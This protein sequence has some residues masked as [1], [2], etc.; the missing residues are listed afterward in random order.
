MCT[1]LAI[2]LCLNFFAHKFEWKNWTVTLTIRAKM[3]VGE[4]QQHTF[5][6]FTP[7]NEHFYSVIKQEILEMKS[8]FLGDFRSILSRRII[9]EQVSFF[10]NP[11]FPKGGE[12]RC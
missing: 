11:Q 3:S 12:G 4:Q 1:S 10:N 7:T 6:S 2:V 9:S 5:S 8:Q